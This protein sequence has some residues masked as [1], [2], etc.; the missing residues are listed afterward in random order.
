[1][2]N[3]GRAAAVTQVSRRHVTVAGALLLAL[4][5]TACSSSSSSS[6]PTASKP[7]TITYWSSSTQAEINWLDSHFNATHK[8]VKV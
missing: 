6:T 2:R 8:N 3:Q 7:V 1:M 4:A 5:A